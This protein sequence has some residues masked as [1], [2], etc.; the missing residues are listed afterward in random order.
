MIWLRLGTPTRIATIVAADGTTAEYNTGTAPN[1][2]AETLAPAPLG[3]YVVEPAGALIRAGGVA[4]FAR[5]HGLAPVSPNIA[6]LTGSAAPRSP[7]AT[8]FRVLDVLPLRPKAVDARLAELAP[9]RIDIK[10]RGTDIEPEAFRRRLKKTR[11][12]PGGPALTVILTRL[13]GEH[14]ALITERVH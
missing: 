8:T 12:T 11:I 5:T 3:N 6:Y 1:T 9:G 14:R 13:L 4:P 10:K 7:F 2:P